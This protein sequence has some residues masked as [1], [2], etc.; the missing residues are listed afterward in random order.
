M[1]KMTGVTGINEMTKM[2]GVTGIN[3]MTKMTGNDM[4]DWND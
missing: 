3:E 1:T 2:T 4:D